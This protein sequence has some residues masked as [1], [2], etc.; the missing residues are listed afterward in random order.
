MQCSSSFRLAAMVPVVM[1]VYPAFGE[2]PMSKE[3]IAAKVRK[4]GYVCEAPK[5]AIPDPE[6]TEPGAKGWM[7]ECEN[8]SYR[9]ML[10][11][12]A[13]AKIERVEQGSR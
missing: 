6:I 11:P 10:N 2:E 3:I 7:L 12:H 5:S 13:A 8:A 1:L 4:Q 9:V